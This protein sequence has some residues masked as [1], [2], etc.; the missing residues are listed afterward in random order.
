MQPPLC[1]ERKSLVSRTMGLISP[2][3]PPIPLICL[4]LLAL[5]TAAPPSGATT[6]RFLDDD[7]LID[8]SAVI[9]TGT[10]DAIRNEWIAGTLFT[11][12]IVDVE[13]VLKGGRTGRVEVLIPGGIDT[14]RAVP[15]SVTYPGAPTL[16]PGERVLLFLTPAAPEAALAAKSAAGGAY[17]VTGFSQGKFSVVEGAG[18]EP[19]VL[20]DLGGVS[21]LKGAERWAGGE[22][23]EPL[24]EL[25]ERIARR[26]ARPAR[27]EIDRSGKGDR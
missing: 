3:S 20:R 18:G 7:R 11:V 22:R 25:H 12:A 1:G 15:V 21:L 8:D 27:I 24:A 17:T 6:L 9:L 5:C 26:A 14:D 19:M 23:A 2:G 16:L 4:I 10:C 13:N